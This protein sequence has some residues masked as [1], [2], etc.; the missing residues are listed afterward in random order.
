MQEDKFLE[1]IKKAIMLEIHGLRF[2]EV[3]AERCSNPR[4]DM[5]HTAGF[6]PL[7]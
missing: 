3:A 5:W 1:P 7:D 6:W 2:Y 4:E